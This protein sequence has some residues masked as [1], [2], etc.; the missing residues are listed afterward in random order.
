M[1]DFGE[2]ESLYEDLLEEVLLDLASMGVIKTNYYEW[3]SARAH[4][5]HDYRAV[6]RH[7]PMTYDPFLAKSPEEFTTREQLVLIKFYL[8]RRAHSGYEV[9]V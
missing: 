8:Y 5:Y 7:R 1:P 4:A 3:L 2:E 6:H 9:S